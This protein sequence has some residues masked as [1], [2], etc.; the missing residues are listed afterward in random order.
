ME[1]IPGLQ[2]FLAD[3]EGSS[4][5][6]F[7]R[8]KKLQVRDGFAVILLHQA[9]AVHKQ[10]SAGSTVIEGIGIGR[11]TT[12]F[13]HAIINEAVE[14]SDEEAYAMQ[15]FLRDVERIDVG[16]SAALNVAATVKVAARL[17]PGHVLVTIICDGADRY[18]RCV[19]RAYMNTNMRA[20]G[21]QI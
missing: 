8:T 10:A 11:L 21:R 12:N 16:P 19:C 5:A 20:V 9:Y 6:N 3:P 18:E 13:C 14:V 15:R 2:V 17:G 7:V 1:R 4:L